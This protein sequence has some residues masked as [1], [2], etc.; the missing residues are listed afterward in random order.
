MRDSTV[1]VVIDT[2]QSTLRGRAGLS[3]VQIAVGPM[4]D[5]TQ[6]EAIIFF[7]T[8]PGSEEFVT[9]PVG[10][11]SHSKEERYSIVGAIWI[12]KA[13]AGDASI[14]GARDRAYE[15]RKEMADALRADPKLGLSS[16]GVNWLHLASTGLE[17][18]VNSKGRWA[19]LNFSVAVNARI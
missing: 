5:E 12:L 3:G 7:G 15:I 10:G 6:A 16:S 11:S 14:K 9:F 19:Q 4:G 1:P 13:G 8:D 17:Q 2:M 18:G